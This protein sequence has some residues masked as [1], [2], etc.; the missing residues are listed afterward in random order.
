M[1]R[2]MGVLLI[3]IMVGCTESPDIGEG[4]KNRTGTGVSNM[5]APSDNIEKLDDFIQKYHNGVQAEVRIIQ[6]SVEGDPVYTDLTYT[7]ENILYKHDTRKV[8]VG[9]GQIIERTCEKIEKVKKDESLVYVLK[10]GFYG[11]I[12]IYETTIE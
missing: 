12:E 4:S 11:S 8:K 7:G 2:W 9:E 6:S 3:V 10:C 1:K 5:E